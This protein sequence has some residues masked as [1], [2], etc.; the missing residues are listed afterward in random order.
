MKEGEKRL[1]EML[2]RLT[3]KGSGGGEPLWPIRNY[4]RNKN[5]VPDAG[6]RWDNLM[7]VIT[8]ERILE[9]LAALVENTRPEKIRENISAELSK[10]GKAIENGNY[11]SLLDFIKN[12]GR[13]HEYTQYI[14]DM[15]YYK[16]KEFF[17]K[18]LAVFNIGTTNIDSEL[19][20]IRE[21]HKTHPVRITDWE[22]SKDSVSF[23]PNSGDSPLNND[24]DSI[25]IGNASFGMVDGWGLKHGDY[26]DYTYTKN[27]AFTQNGLLFLDKKNPPRYFCAAKGKLFGISYKN[28]W[29]SL[30]NA[31]PHDIDI[32]NNVDLL[33]K[34]VVK[35]FFHKTSVK[36]IDISD[37]FEGGFFNLNYEWRKQ[38]F[39]YYKATEIRNIQLTD[40]LLRIDLEN[41]TYTGEKYK[42]YFVYDF[43]D[44]KITGGI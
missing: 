20:M 22:F 42:G 14:C 1:R 37:Y 6:Q 4:R 17:G 44:E 29:F 35:N 3:Q 33:D 31:I 43:I 15:D 30:Y 9:H 25:G 38:G 27:I 12:E 7:G 10:A 39:D 34:I 41:I 32:V 11:L 28:K 19:Q 40:N 21:K 18:M 36:E 26:R 16:A 23:I 13:Y 8:K 24:Q 2:P 5:S